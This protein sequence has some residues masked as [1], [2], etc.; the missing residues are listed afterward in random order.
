MKSGSSEAIHSTGQVARC[1]AASSSSHRSRPCCIGTSASVRRA[2]STFCT[3][4]RPCTASSTMALSGTRLLPRS[5]SFAVMT[6]FAP[7]SSTRSLSASAE[8]PAN[9]TEC[10]APMRAHASIA[11]ARS[12]IIGRYRQTRSPFC[13]PCALSTFAMRPTL[14]LS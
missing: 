10:T 12:G 8:K 6:T 1:F 7:A 11:Y 14:C 9:T 4:D 3:T 5:P 2:T 13:T